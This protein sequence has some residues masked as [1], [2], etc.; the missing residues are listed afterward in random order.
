[1]LQSDTL[2]ATLPIY[3]VT[4]PN[5]VHL[6]GSEEAVSD[7]M[8]SEEGGDVVP[9]RRVIHNL[10]T[11]EDPVTSTSEEDIELCIMT[12]LPNLDSMTLRCSNRTPKP[13]AV[14][15]ENRRQ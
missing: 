5:E 1:M 2:V 12:G 9:K 7:S 10:P 3:P 14:V 11:R 4:T 15:Q 6:S 13:S 8:T